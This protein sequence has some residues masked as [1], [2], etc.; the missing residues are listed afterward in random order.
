LLQIIQELF[1]FSLEV[2]SNQDHTTFSLF[3]MLSQMFCKCKVVITLKRT[4]IEKT[5]EDSIY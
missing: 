3:K 1:L 2:S 5:Y 4:S